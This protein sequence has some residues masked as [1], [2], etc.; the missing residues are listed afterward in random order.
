MGYYR[1]KAPHL[2]YHGQEAEKGE[3]IKLPE[4]VARHWL[5]AGYITPTKPPK[6]KEPDEETKPEPEPGENEGEAAPEPEPKKGKG[7]K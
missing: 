5:R 2:S 3:T 1:V 6:A 7:G 4:S